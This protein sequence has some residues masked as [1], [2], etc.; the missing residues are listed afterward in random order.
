MKTNLLIIG[1]FLI[2]FSACKKDDGDNTPTVTPKVT[3]MLNGAD[4]SATTQIIASKYNDFIDIEALKSSNDQ[5]GLNIKATATGTYPIDASNVT[6]TYMKYNSSK[7]YNTVYSSK[8][9]S[10][11]VTLTEL[12]AT[13]AKGTFNFTAYYTSLSVTDSVLITNGEFVVTYKAQ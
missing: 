2:L 10:G 11:T 1:A 5:I 8:A 4:W 6:A 3:A 12:T 9:G 13:S 7:G